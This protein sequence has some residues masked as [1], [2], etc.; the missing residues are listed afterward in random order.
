MNNLKQQNILYLPHPSC[1][2]WENINKYNDNFEKLKNKFKELNQQQKNKEK[3]KC[4]IWGTF[5]KLKR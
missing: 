5:I 4:K 3:V 1:N 2:Q